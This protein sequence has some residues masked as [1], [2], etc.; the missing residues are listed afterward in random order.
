M[1]EFK[2]NDTSKAII[3]T[4]KEL[5]SIDSPNYLFVFTHIETND[6]VSFVKLNSDEESSYKNRYN[7]FTINPSVLFAGKHPG[8][9]H[10]RVYEQVSDS[11]TDPAL[12]GSVIENGKL[13]LLRSADFEFTKYESATTFKTYN[14]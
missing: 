4:L 1:L 7:Q 8:E 2:Q 5:E 12:S 3:L 9:W 14:G 13:M 6:K 11:N 10:Y